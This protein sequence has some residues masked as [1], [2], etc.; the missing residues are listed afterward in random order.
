MDPAALLITARDQS[1]TYG[2]ELD[3]GTS[4]FSTLGLINGDSV[5]RVTLSSTGAAA[6]APVSGS[7]YAITPSAA[8][9]TGLA[10]YAISYLDGSLTV[11]QAVLTVTA[12]AKS[13]PYG[14]A[15]PTFDATI[16]GFQNDDTLAVV[17]G[18]PACTTT[19]LVTSPVG[20]YPITCDV[21]GLHAA[22]YSFSPVAGTLTVDPAALTVTANAQGKTYGE[23][24]TFSGTEFTT[25][26]LV[27]TDSVSGVTLGSDRRDR[28]GRRRGPTPSPRAT[29]SSASARP[30]TTSSATTTAG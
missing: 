22:N 10:N 4:A 18:N 23:A 8:V 26:G 29:R 1:K 2:E 25:V 6:S 15:E 3:L 17:S 14:A 7:P 27:G 24:F 19:A 28:L 5:S 12:H 13:R 30:P 20:S 11:D 21:S 16:A 9:G